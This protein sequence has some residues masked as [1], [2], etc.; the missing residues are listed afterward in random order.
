[1]QKKGDPTAMSSLVYLCIDVAVLVGLFMVLGKVQASF[2]WPSS[3][4]GTFLVGRAIML[5]S[6]LSLAA[7]EWLLKDKLVIY[8][9]NR[10]VLLMLFFLIVAGVVLPL[11]M[12]LIHYRLI[13]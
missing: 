1:M 2:D 12:P 3:I 4:R 11:F 5:V 13:Q 8:T 7:K 6:A 9:I 10:R